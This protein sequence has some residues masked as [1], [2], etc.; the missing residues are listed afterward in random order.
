MWGPRRLVELLQE[1]G[2]GSLLPQRYVDGS[3]CA[4]CFSLMSDPRVV[5]ALNALAEDAV[6]A[7]KVAYGRLFYLKEE[8][9][10]T[11]LSNACL[12]PAGPETLPFPGSARAFAS[13][14][15]APSTPV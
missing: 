14:G 12:P 1:A 13:Q 4:A 8:E 3:V 7:E 5:A 11:A 6:W 9:M 15:C 2:Y 10:V